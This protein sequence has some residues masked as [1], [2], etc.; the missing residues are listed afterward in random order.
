[1]QIEFLF[2]YL[3]PKILL[4]TVQGQITKL[5]TLTNLNKYLH[6]GKT[7]L[8]VNVRSSSEQF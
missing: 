2:K 7:E 5:F 1:M 3:L 4:R 6:N 8:N